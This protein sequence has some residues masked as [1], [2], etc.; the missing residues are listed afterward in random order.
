MALLEYS[1]SLT[2]SCQVCL[3]SS[4]ATLKESVKNIDLIKRCYG[5]YYYLSV[6]ETLDLYLYD[7][8]GAATISITVN[9]DYVQVFKSR[10]HSFWSIL[11]LISGT[12]PYLVCPWH[13]VG[14]PSGV[15]VY[16]KEYI[17]ELKVLLDVGHKNLPVTLDKFVLHIELPLL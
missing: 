15:D 8:P 4:T 9:I 10:P 12:G 5:E 14:K 7:Y 2:I 11:V 6:K 16:T 1:T 3:G 13:G 17:D